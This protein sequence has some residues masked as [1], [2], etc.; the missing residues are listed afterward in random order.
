MVNLSVIVPMY[1]EE[2]RLRDFFPSLVSFLKKNVKDYE[3]IVVNDGSKDNT[4]GAVNEIIKNEKCARIVSYKTNMGKGFA[5]RKGIY[6]AK[7]KYVIFIDADGSIKPVEIPKMLEKLKKYDVV[8][9]TRADKKSTVKQPIS[10]RITSSFFNPYVN[11]LYGI[12]IKDNLCGFKGFKIGVAKDLFKNLISYR[13]IFDVE[14]F[15]LIRKKKYSLFELPIYWEHKG[16]AKMNLI[17]DPLKMFFEL[18]SLR[19][20]LLFRPKN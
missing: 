13:W 17:L 9:G 8:V 14:I 2:K 1:N 12:G 10:R 19:L 3:L 7:G 4:V 6:S 18:L 11:L 20:K 5:V 16:N 15:Y